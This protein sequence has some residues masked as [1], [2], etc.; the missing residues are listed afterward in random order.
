MFQLIVVYS[1]KVSRALFFVESLFVFVRYC[2]FRSNM[3]K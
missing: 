3:R 1:P 2:Y